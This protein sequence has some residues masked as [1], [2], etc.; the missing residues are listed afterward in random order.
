MSCVRLDRHL[1]YEELSMHIPTVPLD[2]GIPKANPN[3]K[4]NAPCWLSSHPSD[5][6]GILRLMDY[7][8]KRD[9]AASL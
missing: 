4:P 8:Q 1:L 9:I 6:L 2:V 5:P 7:V 3:A